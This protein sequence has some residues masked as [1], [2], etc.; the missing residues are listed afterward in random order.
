MDDELGFG[1]NYSEPL[2]PTFNSNDFENDVNQHADKLSGDNL[3][4]EEA[5][6]ISEV[7]TNEKSKQN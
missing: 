7:S 6:H 5:S 2:E 4:E 1:F 3:T